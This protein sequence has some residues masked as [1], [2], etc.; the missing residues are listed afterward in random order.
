MADDRSYMRNLGSAQYTPF[1]TRV[2]RFGFDNLTQTMIHECSHIICDLSCLT[3]Q[4]SIGNLILICRINFIHYIIVWILAP[5]EPEMNTKPNVIHVIPMTAD[6][7]RDHSTYS[8]GKSTRTECTRTPHPGPKDGHDSGGAS[9]MHRHDRQ[10]G[11]SEA[12]SDHCGNGW[13]PHTRGRRLGGRH[14]EAKPISGE[15]LVFTSVHT[16]AMHTVLVPNGQYYKLIQIQEVYRDPPGLHRIEGSRSRVS[17]GE[18]ETYSIWHI[19]GEFSPQNRCSEIDDDPRSSRKVQV[20]L[21]RSRVPGFG[22]CRDRGLI[23]KVNQRSTIAVDQSRMDP[24]CLSRE[25]AR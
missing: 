7:H 18:F 4:I 14:V 24:P 1:L 21:Y 15:I 8:N 11:G 5:S 10:F 9:D 16:T 22:V 25:T 3:R 19:D 23:V 12:H 20:H 2:R 17:N 13:F 6:K